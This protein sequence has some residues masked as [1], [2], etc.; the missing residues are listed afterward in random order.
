MRWADAGAGYDDVVAGSHFVGVECE[1]VARSESEAN[2]ICQSRTAAED[3]DGFAYKNITPVELAQL[4]AL[5]SGRP[6]A[7]VFSD[8]KHLASASDQ[9]PWVYRVPDEFALVLAR[10]NDN[11][12]LTAAAKWLETEELQL[13]EWDEDA[14]VETLR[15]IREVARRVVPG[16][17]SL[18][19]WNSL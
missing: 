11:D 17:T 7:S 10:M 2:A 9:G 19:L 4:Q 1:F 16:K 18:L 12:I 3:Y 14:A 5:I 13:M 8:Y 15:G 6:F